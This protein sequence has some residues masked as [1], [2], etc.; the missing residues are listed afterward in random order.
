MH[1]K[2][3]NNKRED[4]RSN[5]SKTLKASGWVF[6]VNE[7]LLIQEQSN[8]FKSNLVDFQ[9]KNYFPGEMEHAF[10]KSIV[11]FD[12]NIPIWCPVHKVCKTSNSS[13]S[14]KCMQTRY[15]IM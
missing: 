8:L 10:H 2:N 3:N 5:T 4:T 6:S 14:N 1:N 12:S 9:C 13:T 11:T 15:L 7:K